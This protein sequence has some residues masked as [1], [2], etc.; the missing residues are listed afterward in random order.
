VQCDHGQSAP[1]EVLRA[2]PESQAGL[3]LTRHRCAVCA[4]AGGAESATGAQTYPE[5]VSSSGTF[6]E[7]ART[8]V[9]VNAYERTA[10]ARAACIAHHG[11][12]CSVCGMNFEG[13]YGLAGKG[14]IHVHHLRALASVAA[15]YEAD[16]VA[17][18]RPVCPNCHAMI[19][20]GDPMYSVEAV[21]GMLRRTGCLPGQTN[22]TI[23]SPQRSGPIAAP[24][25]YG[26]LVGGTVGDPVRGQTLWRDHRTSGASET[27]A[28]RQKPCIILRFRGFQRRVL[29]PPSSPVRCFSQCR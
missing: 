3:G 27:A 22:A 20:R 8:S 6:P 4:Y 10:A 9:T 21:R 7:G 18:L 28:G 11:L 2:L 17:D 29:D 23:R 26:R 15:E 12:S 19:H 1:V 24:I 5:I 14:L 16:P 25:G 13:M